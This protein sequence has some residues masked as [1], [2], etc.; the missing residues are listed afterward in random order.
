MYTIY[1]AVLYDVDSRTGIVSLNGRLQNQNFSSVTEIIQKLFEHNY[2]SIMFVLPPAL[3]MFVELDILF[4]Y[5]LRS[6][7]E[8]KIVAVYNASLH[9]LVIPERYAGLDYFMESESAGAFLIKKPNS[10][11][12]TATLNTLAVFNF[13]MLG[14]WEEV[15]CPKCGKAMVRPFVINWKTK[16][17]HCGTEDNVWNLAGWPLPRR[18]NAAHSE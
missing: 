6:R 12:D 10:Q 13:M 17:R 15:Q 7:S 16:C 8:G 1:K 14:K 9:E 4:E 11:F 18:R 5:V 2:S 3:R